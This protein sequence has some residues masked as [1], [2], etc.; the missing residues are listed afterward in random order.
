LDEEEKDI[1]IYY[2]GNTIMEQNEN[3]MIL[4]SLILILMTT[5]YDHLYYWK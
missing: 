3:L 1:E 5:G 4:N 2:L